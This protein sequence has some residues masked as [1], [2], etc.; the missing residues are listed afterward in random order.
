M[1]ARIH[2]CPARELALQRLELTRHLHGRHPRHDL[3]RDVLREPHLYGQGQFLGHVSE[4]RKKTRDEV[5]A[6]AQGRVWIGTDAKNNGLVDHL[7]LFD[8]AVASAAKRADLGGDYDVEMIEPAL[9]W[10]EEFALS[11][12]VWF[13]SNVTG[14]VV[15]RV[16]AMQVAR[17]FEPLTR[18]LQRWTRMNA[19]DHRYAYCFCDVR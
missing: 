4:G 1:V 14:E 13:A 6:I 3:S 8:Q 9:T 11:V 5:H 12:K 19:R 17:E 16:P 7:G 2:A 10:V 15:A 18:E